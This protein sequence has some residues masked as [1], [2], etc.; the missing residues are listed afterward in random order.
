MSES[1]A[2]E[3]VVLISSEVNTLMFGYFSMISAFLI[4]SYMAATKLS[5]LHAWI[6]VVLFTLCS[7]YI[8]LTLYAFNT[9]LDSLYLEMLESKSS[10]KYEL[11]WFGKNPAWLPVSLTA[12]QIAI[13]VGGYIASVVFFFSRRRSGGA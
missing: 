9:D 1:E 2:Y 8:V 4:M 11:R 12:I 7:F 6:V 13:G 5:S 10:G 3:L